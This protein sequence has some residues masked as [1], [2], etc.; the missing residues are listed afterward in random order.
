MAIQDL[1]YWPSTG[2]TEKSAAVEPSEFGTEALKHLAGDLIDT[3]AE[4]HGVGL[5]AP[6]LGVLKRVVLV[7]GENNEPLIL[8]N[9][10]ITEKSPEVEDQIEGCLSLPGVQLATKRH[11]WVKLQAQNLEGKVVETQVEGIS[12]VAVQHELD[13]L[14]GKTIADDC[15]PVKR[16]LLRARVE[17]RAR[18]IRKYNAR[19]K[20]AFN[21]SA[22]DY[23][24][25]PKSS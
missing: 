24:M 5:S 17:K 13:H 22:K 6:Q 7:P 15:G 8:V 10:V 16:G 2:L 23:R 1:V 3:A 20:T 14:D 18:N 12:G 21:V 9:P 4:Y 11:K 19:K 25:L